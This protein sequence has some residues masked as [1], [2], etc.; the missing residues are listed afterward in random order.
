MHHLQSS[1]QQL[2]EFADD[3]DRDCADAVEENVVVMQRME[4]RVQLLKQEVEARGYRWSED[5]ADKV[6]RQTNGHTDT[7]SVTVSSSEVV[8]EERTTR[9]FGGTLEDEELARRLAERMA[10]DESDENGVH[11]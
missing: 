7:G 5:N 3:G 10:E 6:D 2:Q 11:L 8:G 4:E 9:P 1:N